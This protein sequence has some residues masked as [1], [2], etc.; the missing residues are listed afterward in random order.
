MIGENETF[1]I[2]N[3]PIDICTPCLICGNPVPCNLYE[4]VKI[5]NECK[6]AVIEIKK[7]LKEVKK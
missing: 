1:T 5:C 4:G 3:A 7:Q 6:S 2:N